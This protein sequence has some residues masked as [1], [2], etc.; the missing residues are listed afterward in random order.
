MFEPTRRRVIEALSTGAAVLFGASQTTTATTQTQD[1]WV[2]ITVPE[3][4]AVGEVVTIT[5]DVSVPDPQLVDE[6][7]ELLLTLSAEGDQVDTERRTV[8]T[9]D[10]LQIDLEH[11]FE[12]QD[13]Q[14]VTVEGELEF[15]LVTYTADASA[16]I[17]VDLPER[18]IEGAVFPVPDQLTEDIDAY[19][20]MVDEELLPH[21]FVVANAAELAVV[22]ADVEPVEGTGVIDG[23]ELLEPIEYEDLEFTVLKATN[24]TITQ[25]GTDTTVAAVDADPDAYAFELVRLSEYY[26][27]IAIRTRVEGEDG[28]NV[29]Y[30]MTTGLLS[31]S[32]LSPSALFNR[33]GERVRTAL[34]DP[35]TANIEQLL[36]NQVEPF[37][38]SGDFRT[39]FWQ[40]A[41]PTVDGIVIPAG[42]KARE[43]LAEFDEDGIMLDESGKPLVTVVQISRDTTSYSDIPTLRS[44]ADDGD[45]VTV[46]ANCFQS[47]ISMQ[48]TIEESTGCGEELV[49]VKDACVDIINDVVLHGGVAWNGLPESR[50]EILPVVGISSRD[51][52]EPIQT[53]TGEYQFVGEV[54][55]TSRIDDELPDAKAL[56]IYRLDRLGN[57]DY[58]GI[59][60]DVQ[61]LIET[62][63][64]E[65]AD[66]LQSQAEVTG[67]SLPVD[68]AFFDVSQLNPEETTVEINDGLDVSATVTNSGT[69][70]DEQQIELRL[71]PDGN[72]I[73]TRSMR[74]EAHE[75]DTVT[76]ENV[77]VDETGE[78]T[79]TVASADNAISGTLIVD[80]SGGET[81]PTA[82]FS[83]NPASPTVGD[84]VTFD[85]SGSSSPTRDIVEYRWD[86]TGDGQTDQTTTD[87]VVTYTY[88]EAGEYEVTLTVADTENQSD[89]TSKTVAVAAEGQGPPPVPGQENPPQD[90]TG[91]GLYEDIDGD[92]EFTIGDVQLFFQHRNADVVQ[93]NAEFFNFSGNDP[94]E[95]TIGDVQALFQ[96]FQE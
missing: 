41:A 24:V 84:E 53:E 40:A 50:D 15:N 28:G 48:E 45:L 29:S 82:A 81:D 20:D 64:S 93:A 21:P 60:D 38:H 85:A 4:A 43:F 55:E 18:T 56:L 90:V 14:T 79:H 54:V 77:T 13:E 83:I 51:Q 58:E 52:L 80:D 6:E 88:D 94:D 10:E 89:T 49:Q 8:E 65:F 78:Y 30:S 44:D 63:T 26:Q 91:D 25:T 27:S 87:P 47:T 9:G 11:T 39:A 62:R 75:T 5:A 34:H 2:D 19:R 37:L 12:T 59:A 31:E 66:V 46:D 61:E 92:G 86:F 22:F 73:A 67:D 36:D 95:V 42:T 23:L 7:S 57:I 74:L 69:R 17:D 33:A 16:P 72:A 68:E 3:T 35:T 71:E 76:F 96:R 1:D 70:T 32:D